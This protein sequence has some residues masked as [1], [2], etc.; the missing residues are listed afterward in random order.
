[1]LEKPR[2]RPFP[3]SCPVHFHWLGGNVLLLDGASED[4]LNTIARV[5]YAQA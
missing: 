4:L 2:G 1:M 5:Q 3:M